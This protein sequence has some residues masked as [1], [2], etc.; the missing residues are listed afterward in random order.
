MISAVASYLKNPGFDSIPRIFTIFSVAR[1]HMPVETLTIVHVHFPPQLTQNSSGGGWTK[2]WVTSPNQLENNSQHFMHFWSNLDIK[3]FH[4]TYDPVSFTKDTELKQWSYTRSRTITLLKRRDIFNC[5]H[6]KA[7][8][9]LLLIN[10]IKQ[11]REACIY[12]KSVHAC[13][14]STF[15]DMLKIQSSFKGCHFYITKLG[16]KR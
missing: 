1:K 13:K 4:E 6:C 11:I 15:S 10:S 5:V 8:D 7:I 9:F 3:K 2:F 12:R 14:L 16:S